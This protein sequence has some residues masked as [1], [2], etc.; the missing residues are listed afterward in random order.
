MAPEKSPKFIIELEKKENPIIIGYNEYAVSSHI[1]LEVDIPLNGTVIFVHAPNG[2]VLGLNLTPFNEEDDGLSLS[3]SIT[4]ALA[5]FGIPV[6]DTLT[7]Y[8]IT[9]IVRNGMPSNM[10]FLEAYL[11]KSGVVPNNITHINTGY[12]DF[13]ERKVTLNPITG[14]L[15]FKENGIHPDI[16]KVYALVALSATFQYITN[17]HEGKLPS[18]LKSEY[19]IDSCMLKSMLS[20]VN[21]DRSLDATNIDK[22]LHNY[23]FYL[24][25]IGS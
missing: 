12:L 24:P 9:M 6:G 15:Q 14:E 16:K 17:F 11:L 3:V 8:K 22:K 5:Q 1:P 2:R 25:T 18:K 19:N 4:G 20:P 21:D 13:K 10:G 23:H 7:D